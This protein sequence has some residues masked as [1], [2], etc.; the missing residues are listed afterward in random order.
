MMAPIWTTRSTQP[1]FTAAA[2]PRR[3]A[4]M[5]IRIMAATTM[6]MVTGIRVASASATGSEV[7]QDAPRSPCRAPVSQL[8]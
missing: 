7:N 8:K 6:V 3:V 1:R 2:T 5:A 4:M